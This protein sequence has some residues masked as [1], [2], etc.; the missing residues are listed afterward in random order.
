MRNTSFRIIPILFLFLWIA[1]ASLKAQNS[2]LLDAKIDVVYLA[3]DYLEG[4]EAGSRGERLAAEYIA[5]R[6]KDVGLV[7]VGENGTW[8]HEF[9]FQFKSNPHAAEG[10]ARTGVNVIGY[11][12]HGAANT[13]V[14]GAHFDHLGWGSSSSLFAE[15]KAIHNG[16]D[17]N[18]SGV[19]AL[20]R[21]AA[22]LKSNKKA[23][24]NNYL[25]I[26][27]SGEELGLFGSK[28]FVEHPPI[29]LAKVNYML[30][31]D[32]VGRLNE[33]KVLA[34]NG[35]G[36]S[37]AWKP[38]LEKLSIDGIQVK[39]TD[40][41]IGPS[42]HTSFYLHDLPVL[43]FFTGQ[44]ADYHKPSDDA[45]LVN[46]DGLISVTDLII[47]LIEKLDGAG[48]L[49]FT[50]TK[51]EDENRK[52]ASFKVTL[53]VMPDYV[54]SGEGMRVDGII[55]GRP[56]EK[57]G[58]LKGDIIIKIGDIAVKDIYTYMDGLGKFNPGDKAKVTFKR[59]DEVM[60]K[61]VQF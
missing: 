28:Y 16:A 11:L 2:T 30:N 8:F 58:M 19:A 59:G 29:D 38:V 32:M 45:A 10:E 31:M 54:F 13:V 44:H 22:N 20:I 49:E 41:G 47:A 37:P 15:G 3:S 60:E 34:V 50:K 46:Y 52:A 9:P 12:D 7:A 39:T 17:D 27:F 1:V 14:I 55:G 21:I 61:E 5:K 53:G 57:A 24:H 4:R 18:A 56:A 43:H 26:A 33:E 6:F 23:G 35:A 51:D 42:D 48:K 36:T 25:F 40:S